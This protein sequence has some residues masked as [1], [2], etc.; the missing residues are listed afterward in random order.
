MGDRTGIA[1]MAIP[2]GCDRCT[3]AASLV[4]ADLAAIGIQVR[5]RELDDL[6]GA[7]DSGAKFDLLDASTVILYPDAGSF[8]AQMIHET[9]LVLEHP[10]EQD[11]GLHAIPYGWL[12]PGVQ[13]QIE[14]LAYLSGDAR[15]TAAGRVSDALAT[16][17]VPVA[18]YGVP[19]T[20]QFVGPGVGCR[21][22]T[23][24]GYGLDLAA[25]CLS[26]SAS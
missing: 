7:L 25:L 21:L 2:K 12:P 18:A 24:F 26:G 17:E 5:V 6:Q 3:E 1:V 22:F 11:L 23:S 10:G 15:Q 16:D 9:G 19:Q 4:R 8:L 20:S 14:G 13:R